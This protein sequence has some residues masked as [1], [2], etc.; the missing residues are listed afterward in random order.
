LGNQD[1][2]GVTALGDLNASSSTNAPQ[3]AARM[4]L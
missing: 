4:L 3:N 2:N 1:R